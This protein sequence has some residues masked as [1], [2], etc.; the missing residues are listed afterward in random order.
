MKSSGSPKVVG[1]KFCIDRG[2]TFTDV[3]G[4][5]PHGQERFLKIPS[6]PAGRADAAVIGMRRLLDV[7]HGAQ[8]P[9]AIVSEIRV[10]STVATNALL[11]RSGAR[12]LFVTNRGYADA[13]V[14]G[15]QTRPDLFALDIFRKAP[16]YAGVV[17][18]AGR[19]AANGSVV[20]RT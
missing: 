11:E 8:F 16:L 9:A 5:S 2:G 17:E 4:T 14:I 20:S 3:V 12:T 13:L 6:T 18:A 1:W 15:D 7:P 19:M 10:G